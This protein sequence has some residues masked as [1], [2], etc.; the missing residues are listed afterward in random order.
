VVHT[1][2]VSESLEYKTVEFGPQYFV[3]QDNYHLQGVQFHRV[4]SG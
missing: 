4:E 2:A 1:G 3:G